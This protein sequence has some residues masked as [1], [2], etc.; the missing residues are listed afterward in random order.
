M[1]Y[2]SLCPP[3]GP[4]LAGRPLLL[5]QWQWCHREPSAHR[6]EDLSWPRMSGA[7]M[8]IHVRRSR[9]RRLRAGRAGS[10]SKGAP[11][12]LIFMWTSPP[13]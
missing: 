5:S 7:S 11:L 6:R 9:Q 2:D 4:V 8:S 1:N 10:V 12:A 3:R 13:R